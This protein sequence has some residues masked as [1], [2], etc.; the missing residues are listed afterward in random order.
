[1]TLIIFCLIWLLL[2]FF[3]HRKEEMEFWYQLLSSFYCI[4][5]NH[6]VMKAQPTK[7]ATPNPSLIWTRDR[8]KGEKQILWNMKT[9]INLPLQTQLNL[10]EMFLFSDSLSLVEKQ[11]SVSLNC[12]IW[13]RCHPNQNPCLL[14]FN[15]KKVVAPSI[16]PTH[17]C[18]MHPSDTIWILTIPYHSILLSW[19]KRMNLVKFFFF[20]DI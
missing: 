5:K 13:L 2:F 15:T 10:P 17:V 4:T 20:F 18:H 19:D 3:G 1:M 9:I 12:T 14:T 16:H 7:F 6:F 8:P 11:W